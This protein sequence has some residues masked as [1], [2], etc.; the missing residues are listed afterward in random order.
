M[1]EAPIS[2]HPLQPYFAA[3]TH[4]DPVLAAAQL[5]ALLQ[6][7]EQCGL[8]AAARTPATP[9]QLS[10]V[11]GIAEPRMADLCRALDAHEV[12]VKT[13]GSYQLAPP[14]LLLAAH[15]SPLPLADLLDLTFAQMKMLTN[16]AAS[17]DDY[18]SLSPDERIAL[19]KGVTINPASPRVPAALASQI[20]KHLPEIDAIY[21]RGGRY[22]ELGCGAASGMLSFLQAY[23]Q[24][25]AVGVERMADLVALARQRALDLG[26]S[27]RAHFHQCDACD[28]QASAP[29]DSVYWSQSFFPQESRPAALQVA[30]QSLKPGGF[31]VATLRLWEP[32]STTDNLH[33]KEGRAYT[34]AQLMHSS[35]GVPDM[36]AEALQQE[37]EAADFIHAK[38]VDLGPR[39]RILAQRP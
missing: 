38:A 31:L 21:R 6:G 26:V 18:W 8:L 20:Q 34:L 17:S 33:T 9:A 25:T 35:W 27:D 10:A 11:T 7:A 3:R 2:S 16:A 12:L 14:W 15:D 23:P 19:A 36:G 24:L 22:L 4:L 32:S 37:I 39:R 13:D 29:F 5:L 1:N 28:F 30:F